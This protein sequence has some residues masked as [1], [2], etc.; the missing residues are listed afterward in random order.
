VRRAKA[1]QDAACKTAAS[2]KDGFLRKANKKG[3][4]LIA[5]RRQYRCA[6]IAG[7]CKV[8]QTLDDTHDQLVSGLESGRMQALDGITLAR[9]ENLS[10]IDNALAATLK[11]LAAQE[12]SQRQAVNDTGYLKQLAVEQLAHAGAASLAQGISAAM[13]SL[14]ETLASLLA[15]FVKGEIP[16]PALLAES[17][18]TTEASLG[19]GMGM[20]LDTMA[21][22]A[23]QAQAR[24]EE[25]G[26]AALEALSLIRGQNDELSAQAESGFAG[27]M[28]NL[29]TGASNTF[30]Q[31]TENH[32]QQAEQ[33][34]TEGT[35]SMEQAVAGFEEAL[36]TIGGRVDEA[37]ATSLQE[38]DQ[39]LG[40]DLAKLDGKIA[41]EA[42]KAAKKEQPA[43]KS[44]VA[45]ILV[46]IVIIAAAVISIVTL[47]AGASLFAVILVGALVGAVSG[48]LIQIINNWA[49]GEAWHTGL[50]QAMIMGAIGGAIGGGLGFAGGALAAGAAGVGARA[51]T[52][53]AI[54]VGADLVAEGL[55]QTIG[56][57]AFG[58][59]FNWQGFVTAGAMSGVSFR[60]APRGARPGAPRPDV[61]TP[62]AAGAAGGRRAAVAQIAGGAAVGFGVEAAAAAISGK[63]FDPTKAFSAAASGAVGARMSRRGGAAGSP[64]EPTTRLGRAADRFRSFDPGGVGAR[65][66]T[67]LQGIGGRV[68]GPRP[69]VD[70]PGG[71]RPRGEET[72]SRPA[73]EPD[74]TRPRTP[75]EGAP[76]RLPET[77]GEGSAPRRPID[78]AAAASSRSGIEPSG[79]GRLR[80]TLGWSGTPTATPKPGETHLA[81]IQRGL[82]M[83]DTIHPSIRGKL[84]ELLP[85]IEDP[86]PTQRARLEE[87]SA[88]MQRLYSDPEVRKLQAMPR[89]IVEQQL[90][91]AAVAR[92][93]ELLPRL[94]A[95]EAEGT[96]LNNEIETA[97]SRL[98][99]QALAE[100]QTLRQRLM[101]RNRRAEEMA[102]KVKIDESAVAA[103]TAQ[104]RSRAA[105]VRDIAEFFGLTGTRGPGPESTRL[106]SGGGRAETDPSGRVDI[107]KEA[108]RRT[109]FH[110][111]GHHIEFRDPSTARAAKSFVEARAQHAGRPGEVVPLQELAPS[112][113]YKPHEQAMVGDFIDPYT[114]KV[115]PDMMTEVVTT[116]VERFRT[117]EQMLSLYRQDPEHFFFTL[118]A[119]L[120]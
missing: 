14:E 5:L 91:Q 78:E 86:L 112:A 57:V 74:I 39:D 118:G 66:E 26:G 69:D 105:A 64:A 37:I 6:V 93:D 24:I 87:I 107:G 28:G 49:S 25:T 82:D 71:G 109:I 35:S 70:L 94:E 56:Y 19:G 40:Q 119:I 52:Q 30:S 18:A 75:E 33:A 98:E 77:E 41:S 23:E 79:S 48:G 43:W 76:S 100:M 97:R 2:F 55:T 31:L 85:R 15:G 115:Y 17:L 73:E 65:L 59:E 88:E 8:T 89:D 90:G 92:R 13:D 63:E 53:L 3:Y 1:Q 113:S 7:A 45:I 46:I 54:T 95:L 11:S 12:Y 20:L 116:G 101:G 103:L 42:W 84:G 80:D 110:E 60:A 67:R 108:S 27:Q 111:L 83:A 51:V 72:V 44:V 68:F 120:Q 34:M 81:V 36:S 22:G 16:D 104:G 38:L 9:D 4:D 10:A 117:P 102:S 96:R 32:V 99:E 114:G 62:S 106:V 50:A 21:E 47:G 29:R 61:P 58:Q